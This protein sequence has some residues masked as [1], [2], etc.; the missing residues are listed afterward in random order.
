M[1]RYVL[2]TKSTAD[3]VLPFSV[4]P[5]NNWTRGEVIPFEFQLPDF[6]ANVTISNDTTIR[7]T[8]N[9]DTL[10]VQAGVTLTIASGAVVQVRAVSNQGTIQNFGTLTTMGAAFETLLNDYQEWAGSY[11]TQTSINGVTAFK[12]QLPSNETISSLVWGIEPSSDLTADNVVGVWGL[13]DNIQDNR[14][15]ATTTNRHTVD[16]RVLAEFDEY[17]DITALENDL[18][19]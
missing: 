1:T 10:T 4:G 3:I 12:N 5:P 2:H 18:Q 14:P 8:L 7:D 15:Q 9:A 16:I 13:V 19:I 17:S 11:Q 6:T